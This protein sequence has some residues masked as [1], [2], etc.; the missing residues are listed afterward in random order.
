MWDLFIG[1]EMEFKYFAYTRPRTILS[2]NA[3]AGISS[4]E[5]LTH[6]K[7]QLGT[8]YSCKRKFV[9]LFTGYT[10]NRIIGEEGREGRS[11]LAG[12]AA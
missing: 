6:R 12:I 10:N 11:Q 2:G 8:L 3:Y 9:S 5:T 4:Q 1:N 7:P